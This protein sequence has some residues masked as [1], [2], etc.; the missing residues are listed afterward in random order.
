MP[1]PVFKS[2]HAIP[3]AVRAR[4]TDHNIEITGE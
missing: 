4:R 1:P 2:Q 3:L